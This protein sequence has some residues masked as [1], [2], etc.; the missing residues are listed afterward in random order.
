MTEGKWSVGVEIPTERKESSLFSLP[1]RLAPAPTG[2]FGLGLGL[3][4]Y[5]KS[6]TVRLISYT[7]GMRVALSMLS[8]V[9]LTVEIKVTAALT[10]EI[11]VDP[12]KRAWD[13]FANYTVVILQSARNYLN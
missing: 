2:L 13:S 9:R 7:L 8:I 6:A 5:E 1:N 3:S 4:I 10:R 11:A 12:R